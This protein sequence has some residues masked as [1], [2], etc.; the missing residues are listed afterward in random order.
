MQRPEGRSMFDVFKE[1]LG[2]QCDWCEENEGEWIRVSKI[3][4]V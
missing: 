2:N 1:Q 4:W 3:M